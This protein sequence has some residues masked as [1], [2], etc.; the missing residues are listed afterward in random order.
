MANNIDYSN[1]NE[2]NKRKR[3]EQTATQRS[4][5]S[6]IGNESSVEPKPI[7]I[8]AGNQTLYPSLQ[9]NAL[10]AMGNDRPNSI[11]S[12][13][14]GEGGTQCATI[15][16]VAGI[17]S[18]VKTE[19]YADPNMKLDAARIYISQRTDVDDNFELVS[20]NTGNSK[21]KSAI[22]MKADAIRIIAREGIKLVTRT[23]VHNSAGQKTEENLG[24]DIIALNDDKNLQPMVLGENLEDCL[25]E[26]IKQVDELQN[27]VKIFIDNQE[28][29]NNKVAIHNH[30]GTIKSHPVLKVPCVQTLSSEQ[31]V[32][33][34]FANKI[35]NFFNVCVG[36]Y[37]QKVNFAG[38]INRYLTSGSKQY[39]NSKYNRVN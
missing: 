11:L 29:F 10:I 6:G 13:H 19:L 39:I 1:E 35:D 14:G 28:I 21:N 33:N 20:G 2:L 25:R 26:M 8:K 3:K 15:D 38:T 37:G 32:I 34:N 12:G 16:I 22:A 17:A 31:L 36:Y 23:D 4:I 24:I 30:Y 9:T 27:R 7:Y 18:A 5:T